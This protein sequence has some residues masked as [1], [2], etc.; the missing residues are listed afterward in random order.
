MHWLD[1]YWM[2]MPTYYRDSHGYINMEDLNQ[3][4]VL[5]WTDFSLFFAMGGLLI[6]LFWRF[7]KSKSIVALNDPA[8]EQSITKEES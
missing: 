7:F 3:L 1:M 5:S 6:A 2:V 4:S 8:Y